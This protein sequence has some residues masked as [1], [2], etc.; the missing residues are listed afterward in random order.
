MCSRLRGAL[1][2]KRTVIFSFCIAAAACASRRSLESDGIP[3]AGI[4]E[5]RYEVFKSWPGP[6]EAIGYIAK[7]R[8]GFP[9][10]DLVLWLVENTYFQEVGYFDA[11]GRAF[12][13][14][15]FENEPRWVETGSMEACARAL[16]E[17][18]AAPEIITLP[19]GRIPE[20]LRA[21]QASEA[22]LQI[23]KRAP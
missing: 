14:M 10:G 20:A 22:S 23:R 21:I 1:S 6:R 7:T 4:V 3:V 13:N 18:N 17:L 12:A 2:P 16:L 9:S 11:N 15:P 8:Y 19:A 5:A